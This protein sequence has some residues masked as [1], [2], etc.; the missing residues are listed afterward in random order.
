MK[1]FFFILLFFSKLAFSQVEFNDKTC[2]KDDLVCIK[3][4][5]FRVNSINLNL[6][7][8]KIKTCQANT[9]KTYIL[10]NPIK[11]TTISKVNNL[12][13]LT[14]EDLSSGSIQTCL[15]EEKDILLMLK[16]DKATAQDKL[17]GIVR[18]NSICKESFNT[19][20]PNSLDT[21]TIQK[22]TSDQKMEEAKMKPELIKHLVEDFE[23]I[24]SACKI[25][26]IPIACMTLEKGKEYQK[27]DCK[28]D[29]SKPHCKLNF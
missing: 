7:K 21:K 8:E 1:P 11:K 26:K 24:K 4:E 29:K 20:N 2:K 19:N 18:M 22:I 6:F 28:Q 23:T 17:D 13:K 5:S 16:G 25:D 15:L 14:T 27:L 12:C 3:N 9:F 10:D